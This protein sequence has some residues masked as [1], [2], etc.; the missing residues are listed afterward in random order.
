MDDRWFRLGD[1]GRYPPK[2]ELS[3]MLKLMP[4]FR[5]A[6]VFAFVTTFCLLFSLNSTPRTE[7]GSVSF[8][9][10]SGRFR[11][12]T[13]YYGWPYAFTRKITGGDVPTEMRKDFYTDRNSLDR[14]RMIDNTLI[15]LLCSIAAS[16][17]IETT[18][19]RFTTL[20]SQLNA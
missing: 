11:I 3:Q 1:H 16:A 12:E 15:I 8:Y 20:K 9:S 18:L 19:R 14:F 13:T 7:V 6:T 2:V 4:N 5:L 10:L 17:V